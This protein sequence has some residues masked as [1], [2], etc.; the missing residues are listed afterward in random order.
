M[1][2]CSDASDR[3]DCAS[4]RPGIQ[5]PYESL[6]CPD[7]TGP[8]ADGGCVRFAEMSGAVDWRGAAHAGPGVVVIDIE[9][10]ATMKLGA[11]PA[12]LDPVRR[13]RHGGV[14]GKGLRHE[15]RLNRHDQR[16]TLT[17]RW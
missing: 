9:P 6:Q 2:D 11:T 1:R 4:D 13:D 15:R 3:R 14:A 12:G 16:G 5:A 7:A 8:A 17:G 10:S